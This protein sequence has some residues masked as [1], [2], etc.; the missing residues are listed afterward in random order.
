MSTDAKEV[1]AEVATEAKEK[2]TRKSSGPRGPRTYYRWG[3]E[4]LPLS[5]YDVPDSLLEV[6]PEDWSCFAH[7]ELRHS[8]FKDPLKYYQWIQDVLIPQLSETAEQGIASM[9]GIGSEQARMDVLA[10]GGT[11]A[12]AKDLVIAKGK[13][14]AESPEALEAIQRQLAEMMAAVAEQLDAAG[15]A[16]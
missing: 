2:K 6:V 14:N 16:E 5:D 1:V 11:L 9:E 12:E 13:A 10:V 15:K 8:D 4:K 7:K 3:R